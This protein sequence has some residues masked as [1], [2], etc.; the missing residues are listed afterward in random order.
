M[1]EGMLLVVENIIFNTISQYLAIEQWT[2]AAVAL[3]VTAFILPGLKVTSIFGPLLTVISLSFI[4]A[5]LWD[6]ALFFS[7]PDSLTYQ[8][9]LLV[10]V[11]G[12]IFWILVKLLPGI[13]INSIKAAVAAPIL[14]SIFS[15]L[16]ST[17]A[18]DVDWSLV[19]EYVVYGFDTLKEYFLTPEEAVPTEG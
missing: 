12:V 16:I 15:L 8:A 10:F 14:F 18:K 19:F 4:N 7:V 11:N 3:S 13:E 17:Y 1:P 5:H 2:L 9:G 6:V